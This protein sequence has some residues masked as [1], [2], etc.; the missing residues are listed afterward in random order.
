MGCRT[1]VADLTQ[2]GGMKAAAFSVEA[3]G[4][5]IATAM[6]VDDQGRTMHVHFYRNGASPI[7]SDAFPEHGHV[8][9]PPQAF[10]LM[11]M[12]DDLD[13]RDAQAVAAGAT[14]VMPPADMFWG[15][16]YDH[17]HDPCGVLWT[18]NQQRR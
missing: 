15:D 3:F 10:A 17:L 6:S 16:R 1:I 8:L 7:L 14:T 5:E 4:A 11:P 12:V 9:Q 2:A 18:I 13:A